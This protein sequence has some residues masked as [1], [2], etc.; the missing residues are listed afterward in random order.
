MTFGWEA[1]LYYNAALYD[2][3]DWRE[4][5]LVRASSLSLPRDEVEATKFGSQWKA[6]LASFMAASVELEIPWD[7]SDEGFNAL[8]TA[9]IR[10]ETIELAVV[11]REIDD[12]DVQGLRAT[13]TLLDFSQEAPLGEELTARVVVKP[14]PA[15]QE[16]EWLGVS[17]T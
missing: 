11:D 12:A 3:P 13:W 9:Y 15:D 14:A 6:S 7:P 4:I 8:L 5:D 2:A 16:P 17:L 10:N 1:K